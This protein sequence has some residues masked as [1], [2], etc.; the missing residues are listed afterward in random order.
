MNI[1]MTY[2]IYEMRKAQNL[3]TDA[4]AK[5]SGVGGTTINDIE[6]YRHDPT[7]KTICMLAE[8][9]GTAPES[10]YSYEIM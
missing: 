3:S 5:I 6:N 9:L 10:L 1:K 7:V 4:L 8:A 2:F